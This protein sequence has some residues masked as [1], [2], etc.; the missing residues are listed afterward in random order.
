MR[1]IKKNSRTHQVIITSPIEL[2]NILEIQKK[3][4]LV[5]GNENLELEKLKKKFQFI[6]YPFENKKIKEK[7]ILK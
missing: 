4:L 3:L 1:N 6:Q 5:N 2:K 7:V